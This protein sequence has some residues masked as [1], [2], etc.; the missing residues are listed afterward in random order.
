M[1]AKKSGSIFRKSDGSTN[2]VCS[3]SDDEGH[4]GDI[5][6]LSGEEGDDIAID[7]AVREADSTSP[8]CLV[9]FLKRYAQ[10]SL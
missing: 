5:F 6:L 7:E 2:G 10:I 8:V 9:T 3:L 4:S 1:T